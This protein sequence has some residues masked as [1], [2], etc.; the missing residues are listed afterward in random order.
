MNKLNICG[1]CGAIYGQFKIRGIAHFQKCSGDCSKY[2]SQPD[3]PSKD[4]VSGRWGGFDFNQG[5]EL[6]YTC[7]LVVLKSGS[8]WSVWFCD[9]CKNY[10]CD[11]NTF[12][13]ETIIPI[14]RHT[15]MN[16]IIFKPT[17]EDTKK[18]RMA[19]MAKFTT[20]INGFF[21]RIDHLSLW[22]KRVVRQ[23]MLSIQRKGHGDISL[24][25]YKKRTAGLCSRRD[26][27]HSELARY[28]GISAN[29][30]PLV[31]PDK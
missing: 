10:V 1:E 16:G 25:E 18:R 15:L 26:A 31:F 22:S 11:I 5:Y 17:S 29:I 20:K 7:G 12:F 4:P 13:G 9:D 19:R 27:V 6:C 8:R 30:T 23:N 21:A 2:S 3:Y 28:F 14:G 24:S